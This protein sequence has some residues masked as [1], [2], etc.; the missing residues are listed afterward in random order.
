M[1]VTTISNKLAKQIAINDD[2]EDLEVIS[3]GLEGIISSVLNTAIA[4]MISIFTGTV[5][6]LAMLCVIFIPIR[7]MHKGYHCQSLFNCII[8]SNIMIAIATYLL[9]IM[10]FQNWM[11]VGIVVIVG[12]HYFISIEK[13]KLLNIVILIGFYSFTFINKQIACC[14]FLSIIL[15]CILISGRK[16]HEK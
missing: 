10:V 15:N 2:P 16:L 13:Y 9:H 1:N 14:L 12:I 7:C 11:L 8:Y 3:Y 5:I 4:F 6:E